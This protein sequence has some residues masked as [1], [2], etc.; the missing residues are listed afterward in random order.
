MKKIVLYGAFDRYN[1][2]DNIMPILFEMFIEKYVKHLFNE[3]S[4]EYAAISDSN[5][6]KY[7]CNETKSINDL[8][9]SLP[10]GSVIV[11]VGGEVLCT[12]NQSLYLHMQGNGLHHFAL[13]VFRKIFP[14]FFDRYA[15][16]RY[17]SRW[18]Y[19]F[20]PPLNAF[21]QPIKV[22]FNTV[23]G[24]VK[25]LSETELKDVS[26]RFS[27]ASYISVRDK[28]TF[29]EISPLYKDTVLAP[30]SAYI[31]SDL[32]SQGELLAKAGNSIADKLPEQYL[33]FQAAPGKVGCSV[34]DLTSL[35]AD[36]AKGCDKSV[37]LLPIGY[38]SGH[39]DCDLLKKVHKA[40]PAQ[41]ML[42]HDLNIWEIMYAIKNADVFIGT[43][44]HGVITAMSYSVPH[45]GINP[46]VSKLDAFLKEWS[47]AP[48]NQC[49]AI[50]ELVTLPKLINE[51]SMIEFQAKSKNSVEQVKQNFHRIIDAISTR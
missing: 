35:V 11:V 22:I 4:F 12:K 33:V 26:S 36:L 25:S 42:L 3:F 43:S 50:E 1:Y 15:N 45:F 8:T 32:L 30:D 9:D 16:A 24:D 17:S 6:T 37:V 20:I 14:D 10:E 27:Q 21:S 13:K 39:D 49:Y 47:V 38:A 23:G 28:R 48:F 46:K 31:M 2:G 34:S 5:L 18:Q 19:P 40:L 44:L 51:K 41:T 29:D 7:L